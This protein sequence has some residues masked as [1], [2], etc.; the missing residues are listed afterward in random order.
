MRKMPPEG[1]FQEPDGYYRQFFVSCSRTNKRLD[2]FTLR[3]KVKV[4][5]PWPTHCLVYNIEKIRELF[6]WHMRKAGGG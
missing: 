2:R 5:I 6:G 3:G 1:D 4:N